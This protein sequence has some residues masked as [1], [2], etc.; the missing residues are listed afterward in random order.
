MRRTLAITLLVAGL[1][2]ATSPVWAQDAGNPTFSPDPAH[3]GETASF[4]GSVPPGGLI[5][6]PCDVRGQDSST[7]SYLCSYNDAGSFSGWVVVPD[8]A[9]PTSYAFVFCGP[10]TTCTTF[11]K[12]QWIV[13]NAV[14]VTS[15]PVTLSSSP[16]VVPT[17]HCVGY[18]I[19]ASSLRRQ[20]L[21]VGSTPFPGAIGRLVPL[22]GTTVFAGSTVTPYPPLVPDVGAL[23]LA[24]ASAIVTK[25]C[26]SP[27][28]VGTATVV[29]DQSPSAGAVLPAD[30]V[31]TLVLDEAT[32]TTPWWKNTVVWAVGILIVVVVVV[33]WLALWGVHHARVP[34]SP[35]PPQEPLVT[36]RPV[37]RSYP[38]GPETLDVPTLDLIVT[39]HSTTY[40]NEEQP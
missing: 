4:A 20:G 36:P 1:A 35:H 37:M 40:R 31:V 26:G 22:G 5:P 21:V 19:G 12:P 10:A 33:T 16:V 8:S 32:P 39:R 2:A 15:S 9:S 18:D 13:T 25:A 34:R 24:S 29:S 28:A 14:G 38:S 23:H 17:L 30:R 3:P 11:K 7:P 27:Q 6:G